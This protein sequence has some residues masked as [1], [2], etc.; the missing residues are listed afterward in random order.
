V[1]SGHWPED[2]PAEVER[3]RESLRQANAIIADICA[4]GTPAQVRQE[5]DIAQHG[6]MQVPRS[7]ER[8]VRGIGM[9]DVDRMGVIA[10]LRR[11]LREWW[12]DFNSGYWT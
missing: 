7:Q 3:L 8:S 4:N 9:T 10:R 12:R 6:R 1:S 5:R 11:W 2:A